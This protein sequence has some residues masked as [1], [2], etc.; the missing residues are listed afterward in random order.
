MSF[1][2]ENNGLLSLEEQIYLMNLRLKRV[3]STI[4]DLQTNG[5]PKYG[6]KCEQ[7]EIVVKYVLPELNTI[8]L[9]SLRKKRKLTLRDVENLTGISNAYLSQLETGKITN[10]GYDIVRKLIGCLIL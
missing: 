2:P 10:P 6:A 7:G 1:T 8:N 3:E 5:M 9:K 4:K